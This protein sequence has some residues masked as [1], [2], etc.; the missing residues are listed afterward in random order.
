MLMEWVCQDQI[1]PNLVAEQYDQM[2]QALLDDKWG[3][4]RLTGLAS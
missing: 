2:I 3:S 1:T 4:I